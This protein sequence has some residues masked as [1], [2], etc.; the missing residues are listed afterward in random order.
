M[1][2]QALAVPAPLTAA[3]GDRRARPSREERRIARRLRDADPRGLEELYALHGRAVFGL[4]VRL[5]RDRATAEDLQQQVFTEAWR[6]GTEYDPRRAGLLT[7]LL[8]IARSRAIDHLRRRIPEPHDPAGA[9]RLADG[10]APDAGA[11]Q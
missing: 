4:L 11:D 8:T 2:A 9:A 3:P 10:A 1:S 7:W 6:R 5:V